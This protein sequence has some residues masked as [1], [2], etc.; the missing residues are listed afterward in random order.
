MWDRRYASSEQRLK[1]QRGYDSCSNGV[2]ANVVTEQINTA[3]F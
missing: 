3:A 1:S 2:T